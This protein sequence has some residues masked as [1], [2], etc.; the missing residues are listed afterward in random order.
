MQWF[1]RSCPIV[2]CRP[3]SIA[4][5]IFVPT[6]SALATR[7]GD[8]PPGA[9]NIPPKPPNVPRAPAVSVDSTCRR[10]RSFASFAASMSTPAAR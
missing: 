7:S 4:T 3:L 2:S 5:L 1:T 9:R 10:M 6:P 8:S